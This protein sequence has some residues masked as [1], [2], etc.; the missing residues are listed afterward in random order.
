MMSVAVHHAVMRLL[1]CIF[2]VKIRYVSKRKEV[3][4]YALFDHCSQGTFVREDSSYMNYRDQEQE[5]KQQ[6]KL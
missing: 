2:P 4:A 1:V 6:L 3:T 5:L